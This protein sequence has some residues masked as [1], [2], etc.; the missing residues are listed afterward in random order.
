MWTQNWV[1]QAM[2]LH[3]HGEEDAHAHKDEGIVVE[4]FVWFALATSG[5]SSM[6][7][8]LFTFF[9]RLEVIII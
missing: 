8:F 7:S 2:G 1:L 6:T 4:P 9:L 5:G 3:G